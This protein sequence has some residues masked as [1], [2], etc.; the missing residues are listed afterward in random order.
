MASWTMTYAGFPFLPWRW[1]SKVCE[2]G[3]NML[4]ESLNSVTDTHAGPA[5]ERVSKRFLTW[6]QHRLPI[7]F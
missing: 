7:A 4:H 6:E 5:A 2:G 3:T 1:R